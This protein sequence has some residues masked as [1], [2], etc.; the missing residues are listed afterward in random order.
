[1]RENPFNPNKPFDR[2]SNYPKPLE[3]WKVVDDEVPVTD[4]S[5]PGEGESFDNTRVRGYADG[6][7]FMI[8]DTPG[9]VVELAPVPREGTRWGWCTAEA[10][11]VGIM[12]PDLFDVNGGDQQAVTA[13]ETTH[14]TLLV[15]QD[16]K[17][18]ALRGN[19][20]VAERNL[21]EYFSSEHPVIGATWVIPRRDGG[22]PL[23]IRG[24]RSISVEIHRRL[25][26]HND[27]FEFLPAYQSRSYSSGYSAIKL[28][29]SALRQL[30]TDR[31]A[32]R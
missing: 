14:G 2:Q 5:N 13:I 21:S 25:E 31:R 8:W 18:Y 24:I 11:D 20:L 29:S 4:L 27:S 12:M 23:Q 19:E 22:E 16:G 26:I 6:T 7:K 28:K 3:R 17:L 9:Q 10:S 15:L 32:T 30:E 1:M